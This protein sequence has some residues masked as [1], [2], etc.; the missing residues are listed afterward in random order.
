M[1]NESPYRAAGQAYLDA[2]IAFEQGR[3]S[4]AAMD[5]AMQRMLDAGAVVPHFDGDGTLTRIDLSHAV[6]GAVVPMFMLAHMLA[7]ARAVSFEEVVA[8]VREQFASLGD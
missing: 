1:R 2:L 5:L 4:N 3:P 7:D 6:N 8:D